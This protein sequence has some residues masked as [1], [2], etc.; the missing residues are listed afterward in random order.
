VNQIPTNVSYGK[1]D[2]IHNFKTFKVN[3]YQQ[4]FSKHKH[5]KRAPN[6][7]QM[8]A[9]MNYMLNNLSRK[10]V[11]GL[12]NN[13]ILVFLSS[14]WFKHSHG[15]RKHEF[16]KYGIVRRRIIPINVIIHHFT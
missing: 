1:G 8:L 7:Y 10:G 15:T 2:K 3:S 4:L 16:S 11:D 6:G 9:T 12:Q 5:T 14:G 13:S